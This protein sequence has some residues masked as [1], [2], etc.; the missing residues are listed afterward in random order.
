MTGGVE[1]A[2]QAVVGTTN[3]TSRAV[4]TV[5]RRCQPNSTFSTLQLTAS[6]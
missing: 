4:A 5:G 1:P 2:P 6:P 3:H